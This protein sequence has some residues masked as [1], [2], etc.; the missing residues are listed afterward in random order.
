[1]TLRLRGLA[2]LFICLP[3]IFFA[4]AALGSGAALQSQPAPQTQ[5]PPPPA[6]K[7]P[8]PFETVPTQDTTQPPANQ[9]PADQTKPPTPFQ[10]VPQGTEPAKPAPAPAPEA[11][12]PEQPAVAFSDVVESIEF[13]GARRVP[14]DTLRTLIIT[15]KGDALD[16][17]VLHRDFMSL[18]NTGRFD[19][20]VLEREKGKSGWIIRY[21]LTERRVVRSIKYEGNKSISVSDILDRFK[22]RHVGLSVEQQFEQSRVARAVQVLKEFEAEH[23]R[24]FATVTPQIRQI[25]PTSVEIVFKIDEGV[26]VKVGKIEIIGNKEF[27]QRAIVR[28][29]KNSKPSGIP[30]SI[31][32]ESLWASTYDASK[33]DEDMER[34]RQFYMDHGYFT[35]HAVDHTVTIRDTGGKGT[36][37]PLIHPNKSG[38]VA[39]IKVTLEEGVQYRLGK[40]NFVGVK[41]FRT[42]ETLMRPLFG[43]A[44]G[45]VFSTERL[46]KGF[47]NLEKLYGSFGYIDAVPEPDFDP[48]ET[49]GKMDLTINVDEGKQF[50]VRRID[51]SGN[52]TT[53]DKVI[54]REIMID[55]GDIY[56]TRLWEL[57]ILRLNQLG[58]FEAL[59]ADEAAT[60]TRDTKNDT[61]DI[62]L[63]VKERGKNSITLNGG[64][65]EI[66]GTFI[67]AGYATNNFLGLG[68]TLSL[69]AQLG[70]MTRSVTFGFTEPYVMDRPLNAG[71]TVYYQYFNYDQAREA[72]ILSGENLI[73]EYNA[74]GTQNL[75]NYVTNSYG[76]T[77]FVSYPLRRSFARWGL[78]YS[79][80]HSRVSAADHGGDD[81]FRLFE[82]H[83]PDWP[84]PVERHHHQQDHALLHLQ[85]HRPSDY[86]H[87]R[88]ATV[89]WTRL[90]GRPPRR[91]R[92]GALADHHLHPLVPRV[93]ARPDLRFPCSFAH[94]GRLWRRR[95]P[96]VCAHLHGRRTGCPRLLRLEHRSPGL[97]P[98]HHHRDC[99]QPGRFGAPAEV[100]R[101]RRGA[102]DEC[103]DARPVLPDHL[104]RR[105]HSGCCQYGVPFQD[106]RAADFGRLHGCRRQPRHFP[107]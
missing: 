29:M 58:Y 75:L 38:K 79:F 35:E 77:T 55:E 69:N 95:A 66:A 53:R 54:R 15:K 8:N 105:R 19:D 92:E 71:F 26:K 93:E 44:A 86:A 94:A 100:H 51:F 88:A 106:L 56:N 43:M 36:G 57:S 9:P 78:T 81:L 91:Q 70:T 4:T 31:F 27:A 103:L 72:S 24:Q 17:D 47:K 25:P 61:V 98:Q 52:N 59:K 23:G 80:D 40:I 10:T 87:S 12:K 76:F 37:I 50:F 89:H 104:P 42:P 82:L 7:P 1:M 96:A 13:R 107:Q 99:A 45:D 2:A 14:Q 48:H 101:E 39:D 90:L 67:G 64:V 60:I 18:W 65:S 62:L 5:S 22:E 3:V 84:E 68:E 11:A 32:F 34:I 102:D 20:I 63:K 46:Q 33:L 97:Y 21:N 41:L 74:L 28:V 49:E 16:E 30:H 73:P 6:P 83:E 85:H